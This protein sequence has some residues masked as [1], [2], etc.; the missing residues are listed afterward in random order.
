MHVVKGSTFLHTRG[1]RLPTGKRWGL[2]NLPATAASLAYASCKADG[3]NHFKSTAA[4]GYPLS[5]QD[6]MT[7]SLDCELKTSQ[8]NKNGLMNSSNKAVR[9]TGNKMTHPVAPKPTQL[10]A[11]S[12]L[13]Y[14]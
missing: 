14:S 13:I 4:Y 5:M 9:S 6:R 12:W 2:P 8:T 11:P 7:Y 1:K 3:V 10:W